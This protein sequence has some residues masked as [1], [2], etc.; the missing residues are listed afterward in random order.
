MDSVASDKKWF[1]KAKE[2][3]PDHVHLLIEYDEQTPICDVEACVQRAK[4]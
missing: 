4:F 2:I 3:A 1:I